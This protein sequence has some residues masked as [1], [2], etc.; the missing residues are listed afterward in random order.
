F[1]EISMKS[2]EL[3]NK[4]LSNGWYKTS[5]EGLYVAFRHPIKK[6]HITIPNPR[7]DFGI[8]LVRRILKDAGLV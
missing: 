3:V 5:Q 8:G 7:K 2:S 1:W 4:L 6:V